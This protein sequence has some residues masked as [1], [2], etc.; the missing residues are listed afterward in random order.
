ML[1]CPGQIHGGLKVGWIL[2][3]DVN[4]DVL[5]KATH[6]QFRLLARIEVA[7]MA[8]HGIIA[9]QILLDR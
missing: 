9:V 2:H 7:S 3:L 5:G 8:E 1:E 6:E 4:L